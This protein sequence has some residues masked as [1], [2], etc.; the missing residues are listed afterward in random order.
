MSYGPSFSDLF[1]R[2]ATYADKILNRQ[3]R[4]VSG[5]TVCP[6]KSVMVAIL[7]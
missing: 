1:R 6:L 4:G 5:G 3:K 7:V 2:A